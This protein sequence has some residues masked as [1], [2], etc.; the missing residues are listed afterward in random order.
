MGR[1]ELNSRVSFWRE[2]IAQ[3]LKPALM[4]IEEAEPGD[5]VAFEEALANVLLVQLLD[6]RGHHI[7]AIRSEVAVGFGANVDQVFVWSCG[8]QYS[9]E[10]FFEHGQ[11]A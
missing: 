7:S 9:E 4:H 3:S 5:G 6:L 1:I 2:P 10:L 8:H 11:A